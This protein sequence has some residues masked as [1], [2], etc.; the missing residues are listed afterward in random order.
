MKPLVRNGIVLVS[1][2]A[3]LMMFRELQDL[4]SLPNVEIQEQKPTQRLGSFKVHEIDDDPESSKPIA[5]ETLR[6]STVQIPNKTAHEVEHQFPPKGESDWK[7]NTDTE[8]T[9]ANTA[10]SFFNEL[11]KSVVQCH[12]F[13]DEESKERLVSACSNYLYEFEEW[14]RAVKRSPKTVVAWQQRSGTG[15]RLAG[16]MSAFH[17]A[18]STRRKLEIEWDGLGAVFEIPCYLQDLVSIRS[19]SNATRPNALKTDKCHMRSCVGATLT[20]DTC[21]A[22]VAHLIDPLHII[23]GCTSSARCKALDS[24]HGHTSTLA[25][26]AGCPIALMFAPSQQIMDSQV[27]YS[28]AGTN[29]TSTLRALLNRV[30]GFRTIGLHFRTGDSS[31]LD[32][33]EDLAKEHG[34]SKLDVQVNGISHYKQQR[35][36]NCLHHVGEYVANGPLGPGE[37]E[38]ARA[39]KWVIA[40]DNER[41]RNYFRREHSDKTIVLSAPPAHIDAPSPEDVERVLSN[42]IAEF[43]LLGQTDELVVWQSRMRA[44]SFSK[45][46]RLYSLRSQYYAILFQK[47]S[48]HR[49][50]MV[51]DG[52]TYN[53]PRDCML[54]ENMGRYTDFVL[55]TGL[56]TY[57]APPKPL[58]Q[59]HLQWKV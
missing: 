53:T 48:C 4:R 21:K 39:V 13:P 12:V 17:Y 54:N 51:Y 23:R 30:K 42:T 18:L 55:E 1:F 56:S 29:A 20:K 14:R 6:Q 31:L 5:S 36:M 22:D 59:S 10:A 7:R 26:T 32:Q 47:R 35:M 40:S 33:D 25:H 57:H 34:P 44:S 8:K 46:A 19:D 24:W 3:L 28:I 58:E 43:L 27:R 45:F 49:L 41:L 2:V 52:N 11:A 16:L 38:E 9:S 15:D 37:T 50:E